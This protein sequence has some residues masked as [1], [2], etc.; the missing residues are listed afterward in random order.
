MGIKFNELKFLKT[1]GCE[2][3]SLNRPYHSSFTN[4]ILNLVI[5]LYTLSDGIRFYLGFSRGCPC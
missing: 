4:I 2:A 1:Y 3:Q 5:T